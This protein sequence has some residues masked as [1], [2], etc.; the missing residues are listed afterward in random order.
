MNDKDTCSICLEELPSYYLAKLACKHKCCSVCL[1]EMFKGATTDESRYSPRCCAPI[2]LEVVRAFMNWEVVR[3][4]EKK[5]AE[6]ETQNRTYCS[7]EECGIFIPNENIFATWAS[8]PGCIRVTC[9]ECK[10][11]AH[12]DKDC[13]EDENTLKT[14]SLMERQGYRRCFNCQNGVE[15]MFGCNH[16]R[17]VYLTV[18]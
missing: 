13:P 2:P 5:M 6:W 3:D 15:L 9:T 4:F 7:N 18:V 12:G 10:K 16:I 1:T 8:C 14:L 17:L 11:V